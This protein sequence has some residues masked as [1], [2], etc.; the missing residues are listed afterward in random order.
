[1]AT[2]PALEPMR[3]VAQNLNVGLFQLKV[4]VKLLFGCSETRKEN[5]TSP[6]KC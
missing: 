5:T 1:M 6:R 4:P 3:L 2:L